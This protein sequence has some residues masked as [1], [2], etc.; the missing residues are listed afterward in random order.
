[1]FGITARRRILMRRCPVLAG[2]RIRLTEDLAN[3][4]VK[5]TGDMRLTADP[6]MSL[7]LRSNMN[8]LQDQYLRICATVNSVVV[9]TKNYRRLEPRV[10]QRACQS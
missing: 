9:R 8:G 1:M 7:S 3:R 4:G 5:H 10:K 2:H 6:S